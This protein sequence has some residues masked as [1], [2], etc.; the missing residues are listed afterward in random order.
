MTGNQKNGKK[1]RR[2]KAEKA[3]A[4]RV[5]LTRRLIRRRGK[6][7]GALP[8]TVVHT[9]ARRVDAVTF[10]LMRFDAQR[11]EEEH[12]TSL[13]ACFPFEAGEE[14]SWL[15]VDGL[16]DTQQ[17]FRLGEL[18]GLHPLVVE[19]VASTAQRPK[20]EDYDSRLYIVLRMLHTDR[21]TGE[22]EE[23]QLSLILG[24]HS[25]I[26][27]QEAPGDVFDGV[28][29][30]IRNSKGKI[31][32]RGADYLAY[33]LMDAVVDAYFGI[34]ETL[35]DRL[36]ALE[37]VVLD[38]PTRAAMADL[39]RLRGELLV[40]RRVVWPLREV[41]STLIREENDLISADT[42]VF[43]R[44]TY[45]HAV[46][47]IDSVETLRDVVSGLIELY[48]SNVTMR[49]N[50]VMKVLTVVGTVFIPLTF[51]VGV[52]GMNFDYLPELHWRWSYPLLWLIMI[53]LAGGMLAHF[54]RRGWL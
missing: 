45:D 23:E 34:V 21:A 6:P 42:K 53:L 36:E 47:V 33:S 40:V 49:T 27:V 52:Y 16:H 19:D 4:S 2:S 51:I 28:R 35:S 15:N 32:Q 7:A 29:D 50:D 31:R 30:R 20:V 8:G 46:Q 18:A 44:D 10:D 17:I 12:P 38:D 26:S 9:G 1:K 5:R 13:E 39:H 54:H 43:L 37:D 22:T 41:F 11:F 24:R 48:L 25:L 3:L 14:T